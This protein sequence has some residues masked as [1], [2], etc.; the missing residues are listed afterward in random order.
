MQVQ[1]PMEN[2]NGNGCVVTGMLQSLHNDD[3]TSNLTNQ[4]VFK[5]IL[6]VLRYFKML[7]D[8]P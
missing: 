2:L 8:V 5:M 1:S 4:D 6:D 3:G 7:Q